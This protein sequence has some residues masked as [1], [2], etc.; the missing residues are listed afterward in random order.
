MTTPDER[1]RPGPVEPTPTAGRTWRRRGRRLAGAAGAALLG[2]AYWTLVRPR[3]LN[4]GATPAERERSLPGDDLLA[5]PDA[6]STMAVGIDAPPDAVWPWLR[7][8]GQ[9][10][11]GFYSYE[12]A[13]NLV[14]LDIHNADRIVPEWQDLVVGDTV[15][16]GRADRFPDA[17]LEVVAL[18]PERSL[19][20][21]TPGER[22]WWVWSFVLDP[23]DGERTR[24]LVR[25]RIGLPENP[26]VRAAALLVLDPVSSLMTFGMLRGIRTRA[27]RL[28]GRERTPAAPDRVSSGRDRAV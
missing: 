13:E 20:L 26:A 23:L 27:E 25:S 7:Q 9:N 15:R 12:W 10:R 1:G 21:R 14:G 17:T 5:D 3:M 18:D 8:L 24:L 2:V 22:T 11:G 19:V 6:E 28:A 16:L 4:W